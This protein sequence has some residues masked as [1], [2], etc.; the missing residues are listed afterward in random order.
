MIKPLARTINQLIRPLGIQV[1]RVV[2]P[3]HHAPDQIVPKILY[4]MTV[5]ELHDALTQYQFPDL[6]YTDGRKELLYKLMGTTI[7][8][9]MWILNALHQSLSL[10]GD[11]CEFGVAHGATSA[12]LANEIRSTDKKL[13]L[14]DSFEGLPAPTEKDVLIDDIQGLGSMEAYEGVFSYKQDVVM[15]RLKAIQ[16]PS[17][18]IKIV[19]GFI[20][21][22]VKTA[23]LP[24][25]VSF[26]YIDFD[27]YEPIQVGLDFLKDVLS[28]GGYV[29]I[30]D[31][32][33]FSAGAQSAV[34]EFVQANTDGFTF[35]LPPK[36]ARH[37]AIIRKNPA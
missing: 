30:D 7:S 10:P 25:A 29:V 6:P 34:D 36:W 9:A 12:L 22:T 1:S 17:A 28:P 32:G 15:Q 35:E 4:D 8:E 14:F 33:F 16:F 19:P 23:T 27:F 13:W 37:F 5:E 18:R 21:E 2:A 31:Y 26:A 24:E 3:S 20:E 11:V